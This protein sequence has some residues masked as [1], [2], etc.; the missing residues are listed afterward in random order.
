MAFDFDKIRTDINNILETGDKVKASSQI[1]DL[2]DYITNEQA[3]Y[4][5]TVNNLNEKIKEQ[6]ETI[7]KQ[8]NDIDSM[9][10]A[11]FDVMKKY[12]DLVNRT[13]PVLTEVKPNEEDENKE[14]SWEDIMKMD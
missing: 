7:T 10:A 4:T 14:Q 6:E 2:Q 12:G 9:R 5:S 11:N 8:N 3:E 1:L 13:Q